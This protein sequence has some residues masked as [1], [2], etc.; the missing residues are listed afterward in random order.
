MAA[1]RIFP[2]EEESVL[3]KVQGLLGLESAEAERL[4]VLATR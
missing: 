4:L 1:D 3:K 2:V